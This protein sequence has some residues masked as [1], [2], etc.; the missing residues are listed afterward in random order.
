MLQIKL[1][2]K[3]LNKVRITKESFGGNPNTH[4][5]SS[6]GRR[7]KQSIVKQ[8]KKINDFNLFSYSMTLLNNPELK[9]FQQEDRFFI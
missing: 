9:L 3:K 2:E 8:H 7:Q 4:T 1:R 6:R 5:H